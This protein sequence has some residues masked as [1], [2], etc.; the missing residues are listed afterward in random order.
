MPMRE[1]KTGKQVVAMKVNCKQGQKLRNRFLNIMRRDDEKGELFK[2]TKKMRTT[3][4]DV[5][6]DKYIRSHYGDIAFDDCE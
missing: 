4:Q 3:N 1:E 6:G 2:I 5:V